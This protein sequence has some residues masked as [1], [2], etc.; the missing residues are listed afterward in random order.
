MAHAIFWWQGIF[1]SMGLPRVLIAIVPIIAII[2]LVGLQ[3]ITD[4]IKNSVI[5]K[6]IISGFTLLIC[7]YPF[8]DRPQGV[9]FDEKLFVLEENSL[10]TEEVIPYIKKEFPDYTNAKLY[11]SHPY[12]SLALNVDYFDPKY[13]RKMQYL[14]TD[15]ISKETIIIWDDWFSVTEGG[16]SL[17][18]LTSDN[19]IELM[20]T[21]QR[22]EKDRMIKYAVFKTTANKK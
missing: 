2:S 5:K 1:N 4:R 22:Q 17:E 11:F 7:F 8:Y 15:I 14:Q 16:I 10:I 9:V 21:F 3:T 6:L 20:Q 13:Y 18:F 19:R 12:L